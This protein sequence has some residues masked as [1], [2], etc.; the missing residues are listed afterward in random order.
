VLLDGHVLDP[1][2]QSDADVA[3]RQLNEVI[4]VDDRAESVMLPVRDGIT[5][6]RKR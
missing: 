4:A 5:L 2:F 1:A 6:A 3:M